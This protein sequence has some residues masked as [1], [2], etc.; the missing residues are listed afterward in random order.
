M[1]SPLTHAV[2]AVTIVAVHDLQP[3]AAR[4]W[5]VAIACA[6]APDLDALGYWLGVPY[7]SF[8]GHR[9]FTHSMAFAVLLSW[10]CANWI[11]HSSA[12]SRLRLWSVYLMAV[13]SHDVL[14]AMTDGGLGVALF[15][16]L[17]QTRYFFPFRPI[18][19]SSLSLSD[20]VG[21]HGLSVL[22][23]ECLWVWIPCGVI[24]TVFWLWRGRRIPISSTG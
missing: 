23:N 24:V 16:P 6:I 10:I 13:L 7:E 3:R 20:V 9:G 8:W 19:V 12:I 18:Q 5:L 2:V 15:S 14:D 21:P 1:A 11:S 4:T 22:A 17:D